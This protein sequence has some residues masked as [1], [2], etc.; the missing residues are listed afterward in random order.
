[1]MTERISGLG[2]IRIGDVLFVSE[3]DLSLSSWT[4]LYTILEKDDV[5]DRLKVDYIVNSQPHKHFSGEISYVTFKELSWGRV[6]TEIPY[7]P[8]QEPDDEDDV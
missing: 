4:Y 5:Y 3:S 8:S 2:D 6:L 7:D 1:M